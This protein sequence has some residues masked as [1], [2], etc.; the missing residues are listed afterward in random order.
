ML[1]YEL[2]TSLI[3]YNVRRG[4]W[5]ASGWARTRPDGLTSETPARSKRNRKAP[6]FGAAGSVGESG[7]AR[8]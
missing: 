4:S 8:V 3:K 7:M 5:T 6:E 1:F 2:K